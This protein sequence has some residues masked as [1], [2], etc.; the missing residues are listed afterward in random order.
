VSLKAFHLVFV[1]LSSLLAFVFAGWSLRFHAAVGGATYLVLGL[2]SALFGL[3]LIAYGFWFRRKIRTREEE[4][5][6]RRKLFRS[7]G[8]LALLALAATRDASA[9]SACY[10]EAAGPMI[11]AAR[12]GVYV[13]FALVLAVQVSFG[14]FFVYL[15]R[16]A[17]NLRR[18]ESPALTPVR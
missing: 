18:G 7:V 2:G 17:R 16:R 15:W 11:D 4:Q 5:R 9:C 12:I 10:G 8:A 14:A 13:L 1:T 6:E 3:G